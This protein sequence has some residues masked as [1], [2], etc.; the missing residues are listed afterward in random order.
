MR[1]RRGRLLL[2]FEDLDRTRARPEFEAS[3]RRDL[4]WL[5]LHWDRE[6]PHQSKRDYDAIRDRLADRT[7][8]CTCT[9][10]QIRAAGGVYPGTCRAVGR[11]E[12]AARFRLPAGEVC[13]R[14]RC[15]GELRADPMRCGD[16]VLQRRDGIY[17]YTLAVVADD[18]RD[19]V[20]EVARGAD[21]L[22][23]SAVQIRLW[24]ALGATTPDWLH[25][26]LIV[27]AAGKKLAKSHDAI[28]LAHLR[29]AGWEPPHIWSL[30]LPWLGSGG[31]SL[32]DAI[33]DF[34]PTRIVR[35]AIALQLTD[36]APT[37]QEGMSWTL[38][39]EGDLVEVRRPHG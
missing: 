26:P 12:G 15:W 7:Y 34:D 10:A 24:E 30:V 33:A 9:R 22:E 29:A 20:T 19:R 23:A 28:A 8:F 16:P 35:G 17:S 27:D 13:F 3:Q 6:V 14:D 5:G 25:A 1:S 38:A 18:W 32:A 37:P 39:V 21:L 31:E 11:A 4:E 2:R 36:R